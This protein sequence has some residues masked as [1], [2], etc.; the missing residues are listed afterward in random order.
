MPTSVLSP[1]ES[2]LPTSPHHP[3]IP[4]NRPAA[5]C[6]FPDSHQVK[7]LTSATSLLRPHSIPIE[8]ASAANASGF[9][10]TALSNAR[11]NACSA[12]FCRVRASDKALTSSR[13]NLQ[14]GWWVES[15]PRFSFSFAWVARARIIPCARCRRL[16]LLPRLR[17]PVGDQRNWRCITGGRRIHHKPF[18]IRCGIVADGSRG[19]QACDASSQPK[20]EKRTQGTNLKNAAAGIYFCGDQC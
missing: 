4:T 17:C 3:A 9:L 11:P 19:I 15:G 7:P 12:A 16:A 1:G 14:S 20:M 6:W 8:P 5:R 18:S 10:L 13:H 2:W